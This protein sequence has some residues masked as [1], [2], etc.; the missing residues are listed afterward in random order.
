M[1]K[2]KI[3]FNGKTFTITPEEFK[4]KFA[5][6][7]EGKKFK[8]KIIDAPTSAEL[9]SQP[10]SK[11][12][13]A[14]ELKQTFKDLPNTSTAMANSDVKNLKRSAYRLTDK[15]F[16][17]KYNELST[18]WDEAYGIGNWNKVLST[19]PSLQ[20]ISNSTLTA[21]KA[22][23]TTEAILPRATER[24]GLKSLVG[25]LADIA[26]LPG[27]A[28]YGAAKS[29]GGAGKVSD[30][31]VE[32]GQTTPIEPFGAILADPLLP[33]TGLG[34]T[35]A[36]TGL[37]L[38]RSVPK[39]A[40][41]VAS[42]PKVADIA[43]K[44]GTGIGEALTTA[45]MMSA[46]RG[47]LIDPTSIDIVPVALGGISMAAPPTM[48]T[49]ELYGA[50]DFKSVSKPP[51]NLQ[52]RIGMEQA[53]KPEKTLPIIREAKG[54]PFDE[55]IEKQMD[56]T[57]ETF[58]KS[59]KNLEGSKVMYEGKTKNPVYKD[60][61]ARVDRKLKDYDMSAE[62]R[63]KLRDFVTNNDIVREL[64]NDPNFKTGPEFSKPTQNI[65]E[66]NQIRSL[67]SYDKL[68]NDWA[69]EMKSYNKIPT[70]L[71]Q[72]EAEAARIARD[73][74]REMKQDILVN[75]SNILSGNEQQFPKLIPRVVLQSP[76]PDPMLAFE[77]G[78][79]DKIGNAADYMQASSDYAK[80]KPLSDVIERGEKRSTNNVRTGLIK[81]LMKNSPY[82]RKVAE[83]LNTLRLG[84]VEGD[85]ATPGEVDYGTLSRLVDYAN[86]NKSVGDLA[87]TA[88]V[89]LATRAIPLPL[90]TR[91]TPYSL[92]AIVGYGTPTLD[93]LMSK[94]EQ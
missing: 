65:G 31:M 87:K 38:A 75:T 32:A 15:A 23:T 63:A 22:I 1:K 93:L 81:T 74:F 11:P 76:V 29:L 28:L 39:I 89:D 71:A 40:E 46:D 80:Y 90:S 91:T 85:Y 84:R 18:K 68:T 41:L 62:R 10:Q 26:S 51:L 12:L 64:A 48:Q 33:V 77:Q 82:A 17:D 45:G 24:T 7:L 3:E 53:L 36:R 49:L 69:R 59:V 47:E 73:A 43:T 72:N 86:P 16:L 35:M 2:I 61:M 50:K 92:R 30:A 55:F 52:G 37:N 58:N 94:E 8:Y 78:L 44:I 5:K 21:P 9:K 19:D 34:G 25:G 4:N 66:E 83:H 67:M 54:F 57:G 20:P 70:P 6:V 88:G 60:F 56:K 42:S 13:S 14:R 79:R 27:R